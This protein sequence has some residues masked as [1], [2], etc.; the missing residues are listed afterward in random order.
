MSG[1]PVNRTLLVGLG[2]QGQ[3]A[4]A[5]VKKRMLQAYD[6]KVPPVVK[7]LAIDADVMSTAARE[8][9]RTEEFLH[10]RVNNVQDFIEDRRKT[11]STWLD[12]KNIPWENLR[13]IQI[14]AGQVRMVGRLAQQFYIR[15]VL[16]VLR[17]RSDEIRSWQ[18]NQ[19]ETWDVAA[20][21]PQVVFFGSVAGG[22]GS[23]TLL[24]LACAAR[25]IT[26]NGWDYCA[27]LMLPGVFIDKPMT[28]YVEENSYA[29]LKELDFLM[30]EREAIV[31]GEHGDL[32]SVTTED[33]VEYKIAYPFNKITL[34]DNVSQGSIENVFTEPMDLAEAIGEVIYATTGGPI[35]VEE[36]SAMVNQ[37]NFGHPWDGGRRAWYSG[38]GIAVLRYPREEL[39]AFGERAFIAQLVGL[40]KAGQPASD[41][42]VAQDANALAAA[43][44][45]EQMLLQMG[46]NQNQIVDAIL[47]MSTF[48][49]QI[50]ATLTKDIEVERVWQ[51]NQGLLADKVAEWT[52]A[53]A[54]GRQAVVTRIEGAL[55]VRVDEL[56]CQHAGSVARDFVAVLKGYFAGVREEMTKRNAAAASRVRQLEALVVSKKGECAE[57]T[58]KMFGKREAVNSVLAAYRAT[59]ADLAR[60]NCEQARTYEATNLCA[61]VILSLDEMALLL[62]SQRVGL[63][64]LL[65]R[66]A[67]EHSAAREALSKSKPF[68]RLV[69]PAL[70]ALELPVPVP[71]DFYAWYRAQDGAGALAFWAESTVEAYRHLG[72]YAHERD[73]AAPLRKGSLA[74]V[75]AS[76]DDQGRSDVLKQI[77]RSAQPLLSIDTGKVQGR[78]KEDAPVAMYIV[79][80]DDTFRS[81]FDDPGVAGS[82][83]TLK[84]R[85]VGLN[86]QDV[87]VIRLADPD[88]AFF[89]RRWGCVPA[90]GLGPFKLLKSEYTE[91]ASKVGQWSLHLDKRWE[92]VL[93]DLDP[94]ATSDEDDWVWAVATSDIDYL[95]RIR[96]T[97]NHYTLVYEQVLADGSRQRLEVPLGN[98]L[99][100]ART[101]FRS[102]DEWVVQCRDHIQS[103]IKERVATARSDLQAYNQRLMDDIAHADDS[104]KALLQRDCDAIA[105]YIASL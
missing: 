26:G 97:A 69:T 40:L 21:A 8:Q 4:L 30:T 71:S 81:V 49:A 52:K 33:G 76:L 31:T 36:S 2:G 84:E 15:D 24:D 41:G 37:P 17:K 18:A 64:N 13:N 86:V 75:L 96:R 19:D 94:S 27:Y 58:R 87:Q 53:A 32:F 59:L 91:T 67:Q 80:A 90:Y 56:I 72:A 57:K 1:I 23:G 50:P 62:D 51:T 10:L 66:A 92:D 82:T 63:S 89:Y 79:A 105:R 60:A 104:R 6:G 68:E 16:Q 9:L 103:A 20:T 74:T 29:F 34:I 85:L 70:E 42:S 44:E 101:A 83:R 12:Y 65:E 3:T 45:T 7:F 48:A 77:D 95:Q 88:R 102:N 39:V 78:R 47:A 46:D 93:P 35:G 22:T 28:Y 14:G 99:Q 54:T 73:V 61:S 11:L 38:L 100:A 5:T 43:F 25:Q 98:G 55:S